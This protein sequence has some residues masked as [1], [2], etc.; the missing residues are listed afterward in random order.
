[1]SDHQKFLANLR[2]VKAEYCQ[3]NN[4]PVPAFDCAEDYFLP[5]GECPCKT[6]I[7]RDD[8]DEQDKANCSQNNYHEYIKDICIGCKHYA[9]RWPYPSMHPCGS[10]SRSHPKDYYEAEEEK[11]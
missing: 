8:C 6:C 1:M 5:S 10:C 4:L 2:K 7:H 9:F 11:S 3:K